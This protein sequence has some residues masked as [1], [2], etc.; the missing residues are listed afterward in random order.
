MEKA[1]QKRF[2]TK[3]DASPAFFG[4]RYRSQPF[5]E[6]E[7]D[8]QAKH[9]LEAMLEKGI[10]VIE[11]TTIT[12][13]KQISTLFPMRQ[14]EIIVCLTC[15][16][17][18]LS[19][20]E[21]D[22]ISSQVIKQ[23][24]DKVLDQLPLK[25]VDILFF[26]YADVPAAVIENGEIFQAMRAVRDEGK[27]EFLGACIRNHPGEQFILSN[28]FD[29]IQLEYNLINQTNESSIRLA[30]EKGIGVFVWNGLADGLLDMNDPASPKSSELQQLMEMVDD[31]QEKLHRLALHFIH[32]NKAIHSILLKPNGVAELQKSI[33]LLEEE[34]DEWLLQRVAALYQP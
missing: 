3:M 17:S 19:L 12:S 6:A 21:E 22:I 24:I 13:V 33:D 16:L 8:E 5:Q 28:T 11:A 20:R 7:T 9:R 30:N 31:D 14:E 1:L 2:I 15:G 27:V 10:N 4:V 25:T 26:D 18:S 32:R 23:S 29:V 34:V